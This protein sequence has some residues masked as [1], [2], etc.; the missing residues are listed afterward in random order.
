MNFEILIS[1][2]KYLIKLQINERNIMVS[3]F[4]SMV[5]APLII[6]KSVSPRSLPTGSRYKRGAI[7]DWPG[8]T[9]GA[10]SLEFTPC[11]DT[12]DLTRGQ[13]SG[14]AVRVHLWKGNTRTD[15]TVPEGIPV[16]HRTTLVIIPFINCDIFLSFSIF[17]LWI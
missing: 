9:W 12:R 16:D 8:D 3:D 7:L 2:Q 4:V 6:H 15:V 1:N 11:V 17:S 13:E 5:M 10:G 14:R